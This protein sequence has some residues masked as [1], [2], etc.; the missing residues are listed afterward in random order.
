MHL[1]PNLIPAIHTPQRGGAGAANDVDTGGYDVMVGGVGF[2]LAT[3]Q[4]FPYKRYD[5]PTT[6]QRYDTSNEIGEH[7]LSALPWIASQA[8][9]HGGAGQLNL[10]QPLSTFQYEQ[11]EI[12]HIRYDTSLNVDPWTPGVVQR[13]PDVKFTSFGVTALASCTGAVA[14]VDYA[15]VGTAVGLKQ[16]KWLSGPDA[17]ATV[18]DIDLTGASFGGSSNCSAGSVVTNGSKWFA[19][20]TMAVLTNTK[21][22]LVV[23]GSFNSTAAPTIL[24]SDANP[25]VGIIGWSKSRLMAGLSNKFYELDISASNAALPT[26]KYTHPDPGWLWTA[27]S[28]A[29]AAILASGQGGLLSSVLAFTLDTSGAV[30]TLTGGT[31]VATMPS[32]EQLTS[33]LAFQGSFVALGT[34]KGVHLA[35]FDTY[36]GSMTYGPLSLK[37][38]APVYGL[39]NR[40]RFIFAGWSNQQPDGKTGLARI[41]TTQPIDPAGRLAWAPDI[42]PPT[43][44]PTGLGTVNDVDI[45]PLSGRVFFL[46]PEGIHVEGGAPGSDGDAW[47]R[48]SRIR[49][50]T[51]ELKLFKLGKIH[52]SLA[53]SEVEVFGTVPFRPELG[54]GLF[55][56]IIDQDPGSFRLNTGLNE[57]LQL[58]F[59]LLGSSAVLNSYQATALPAPRKQK[60]I[61]FTVMCFMNE[62]TKEGQSLTEAIQPRDRWQLVSEMASVGNEIRFVEFTNIGSIATLAVIDKMA[63]I[64]YN[65]PTQ[66]ND[67]GGYI[68]FIL[69]TTES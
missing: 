28:E 31:T 26:A 56:F 64:S 48:T 8:S 9:F 12:A 41:D 44:A 36:T 24:Y 50:D 40:D 46:T 53:S 66:D 30:P 59:S 52:G 58:R 45:L 27:V 20:I 5:E 51:A 11:A 63:F 7:S 14:G 42:R 13:L 21:R 25:Y 39:A 19:L 47:L 34:N 22:T 43:T 3:D 60:L 17:A 69:R 55:G 67:F 62:V 10:E 65:R 1:I 61:E 6:S 32:G 38:T 18:T 29:P 16:L 57:W 15:I 37:S 68:S 49:F 23:S 4:N 2:R 54:L 35:T 33:M